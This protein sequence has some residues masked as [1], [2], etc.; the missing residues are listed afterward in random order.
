[1][2]E[3]NEEGAVVTDTSKSF[4]SVS[5]RESPKRPDSI[6]THRTSSPS[7]PEGSTPK[8]AASLFDSGV[9]SCLESE[10]EEL[11]KRIG[12]LE[13]KLLELGVDIDTYTGP[14]GAEDLN[15]VNSFGIPP[16]TIKD[17]MKLGLEVPQCYIVPKDRFSLRYG[18]NMC[19]IEF[20]V[21]F[22]FF[23]K[24][25]RMQL[26][27]PAPVAKIV[28]D[29][30]VE[31]LE[32][33][34][35]H[36]FYVDQEYA[37]Q[38]PLAGRYSFAAR[39]DHIKEINFFKEPR[40]GRAISADT[41]LGFIHFLPFQDQRDKMSDA[42]VQIALTAGLASAPRSP[43]NSLT[44]SQRCLYTGCLQGP[45]EQ[46]GGGQ[47][48]N[49]QSQGDSDDESDK[50]EPKAL[51]EA[52]GGEEDGRKETSMPRQTPIMVAVFDNG[53]EIID[54]DDEYVVLDDGVEIARMK[55]FLGSWTPPKE[56]SAPPT[57][58]TVMTP[59]AFGVTVLGSSH[60]FDAQGS[61]SGFVL[62]INRKGI[63]VD[64]P[65][66]ATE[67]LQEA[68]IVPG[69][70]NG[71]ILTHCHADH[72][73]GTFQKILKE[74]KT[75]LITTRTIYDSFIRK[76]ALISGFGEP[77][78]QMLFEHRLVKIGED[79]HWGGGTLRFFYSLHALPCIGF[80]AMVAG[81]RFVYS[82][83]TFYEPEGLRKLR[84][85]NYLSHARCDALVNFPWDCDVIFHE[86]GIPPIHTPLT[87]LQELP[88]DVRSRLYI[89]HIAEKNAENSG[90][91][92]ARAGVQHTIVIPTPTY[93]HATSAAILQL[94]RSTDIFRHFSITQASD[95]L[96][97]CKCKTY[98]TGE[99]VCRTGDIG[100]HFYVI[101]SGFCKVQFSSREDQDLGND[102]H[103]DQRND[104]KAGQTLKLK[105]HSFGRKGSGHS[106]L[107][108]VLSSM[109]SSTQ[110]A[111]WNMDDA[112]EIDQHQTKE[113]GPGDYFGELALLSGDR[114]RSADIVASTEMTLIELDA[115]AFR[116]LL[117]TTPGL[118]YRMERLSRIRCSLSWKAIGANSVLSRL[119]SKQRSQL[120]S[121]LQVQHAVA[122]TKLWTKNQP[123]T[124][125]Y[126]LAGG[127][128]DV[129]ELRDSIDEPFRAG[130]FFC[131]IASLMSIRQ[132][133]Q[134]GSSSLKSA[135]A[136]RAKGRSKIVPSRISLIAK[137]DV[138]LYFIEVDDILD[139]LDHNPG[140]L[141][142]LIDSVVLE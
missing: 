130:T 127:K 107:S 119:G 13:S 38:A 19:E 37:Q 117:D 54:T 46:A 122:G 56:L 8:T 57:T 132:A 36:N 55:T 113:F 97:L 102:L 108:A 110:S 124:C 123:T 53:L 106:A 33:P 61:T 90:L 80:E 70:I 41:A 2:A 26:V 9:F 44:A 100:D 125:A 131:N 126:L 58:R 115:H 27:A 93:E 60:G 18:V 83:D 23:I 74:G 29:I 72:D 30:L 95:L 45:A 71:I 75:T 15:S 34:A 81:K 20:P 99:Y 82:A 39:P 65:P 49:A 136:L 12:F 141:I 91:R 40:D 25:A 17:C 11:R 128:V 94:L 22:N 96:Q 32:G 103:K 133:H 6:C 85:Q 51:E 4:N 129:M 134:S 86:A 114:R 116:Y 48:Q 67:F 111:D 21:Y 59:P 77:F 5:D 64:P 88:E 121:V 79:V 28:R 78:L 14:S 87:A 89:I 16:E 104:A 142:N 135:G 24:Q 73:A 47:P 52:F 92:L 10:N 76:Y 137:T 69:M 31:T 112:D 140:V 66:N 139:F 50:F 62:W 7:L 68:G 43:R 138:D 101:L 84:D 3:A 63:M 109:G 98:K 42:A 120:Q 35:E 118:E 1:M 105:A